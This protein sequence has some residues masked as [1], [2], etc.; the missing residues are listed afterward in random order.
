M[1]LRSEMSRIRGLQQ[2]PRAALVGGQQYIGGKFH[3]IRGAGAA[4][5]SGRSL[6]A[7]A[8]RDMVP[9]PPSGSRGHRV[10]GRGKIG[11]VQGQQFLLA[12]QAEEF[13]RPAVAD[14]T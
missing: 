2:G 14:P 8:W 13:E 6:S 1:A 3:A 7:M 4:T 9:G 10:A 12:G 5:R 11:G